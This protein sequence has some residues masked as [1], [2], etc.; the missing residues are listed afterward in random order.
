MMTRMINRSLALPLAALL[1]VLP[2][3][4]PQAD[5]A[6][7]SGQA[8]G[9]PAAGMAAKKKGKETPLWT[10]V[11]G[12]EFDDGVI[13]GSKWTFDLTNGASVGNPGWGNNE[14]QYYTNR[15]ENVKEE[16]GKLVITAL[17][18]NY[19][20]FG[21]TSARIKTK[22]L[23][24][25]RYGK[26]EI[27]A[28]APAGKGYWPAI[29]M[30][31]EHN[32]YGGWAASGEIDIMEGWGSR[33]HTIAGT[34]HYGQQWPSNTYSGKEYEL[35]N[36]STIEDYHTY[37]IEWEPGEI[38]W[39]VDGLL[40]ST[41]NDW[42]SRSADQP[43]N[44]AYPAPFD[45][46]FH[47]L[48]NLA[49]GG[50][51]DGSP[52]PDT[53]FPKSM[54]VDYVRVY[55]LT[56]RE[57]REP[58][59]PTVAKEEYLPGAKLPQANGS[60]IYN[61][62]FTQTLEADPGM[63]I[64]GTAHW[65]LYKDP[66]AEADVSLENIGGSR[67]A[68][69]TVGQAGSNAYSIQPQAIV[70]LAK[71]R[72]YKLSFDAKT[73]TA[74]SMNVKVTGGASVGYAGYSQGLNAELTDSVKRYEM[75]F[76][77]KMASDNAARIEFNLGS[78]AHP[79]WIGNARL[80]E[81]EGIPFEH[82]APKAPLSSGNHVYNGT[83]DIGEPDGMSYWHLLPD[84]KA[85]A[86]GSVDA[87]ERKLNV[88]ITKNGKKEDDVLLL[89]KGLFLL[90]GHD[91]ALS[92]DAKASHSRVIG[93]ELAGGDGKTYAKQNVTLGRDS[94]TVTVSFENLAAA[95]DDPNAQLIFHLGG[96]KGT[97][98][99]DNI[100]L[101]RTS[102]YF[103]PDTVFYPLAN[104]DFSGGLNPWQPAVDSGGAVT[105]K[106]V[107]GEAR[108][109]VTNQ[110]ANP[111]SAMFLQNG[112]RLQGGIP[113]T[114]S[115][116]AR[117]SVN[118]KLEVVAE[119]ASYTR[120]VDQTVDLT[121][122]RKTH[123]FDFTMPQDDTVDLKF[124]LG[125]I[126]GTGAVGAAHDVTIDNVVFQ[127]KDAPVAQPPSLLQDSTGNQAGQ[128]VQISFADRAAWRAALTF[129]SVNG[130][131][132]DPSAY[133]VNPG[134]LDISALAFPAA[135]S[136]RIEVQADGYAPAAVT[137]V[138]L[139]ADGN[140]VTNGGFT[141]GIRGWSTWSGEGGA[142]ELTAENGEA[143]I[144]VHSPGGPAW[145]N[146]LYQEGIP[147][148]A[149]STYELGFK[150]SSTVNRPVTVEFTGTSGGVKT[151]HLTPEAGVYTHR[152]TVD[153]GAPLKLNFLIGSV[154]ADGASTPAEAHGITLGEVRITEAESEPSSF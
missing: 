33:P 65:A 133:D 3:G 57:Y 47:L 147:M 130:I 17:K 2:L 45:E 4:A 79:A 6:A 132:L 72:Y 118:R 131:V 69:V 37:A 109:T 97:L 121:P 144:L 154:S 103:P 83:F 58:V 55:E 11:W 77:M 124:L 87:D 80:E 31:P 62:G 85:A 34:I 106:A 108:L 128:D 75:A 66:G 139:A 26:F 82:D 44:N 89:Q 8:G 95:A 93:V 114:F 140:L 92:F 10:Q 32:R 64:P 150:A 146:Q 151:F 61:S 116:D 119:N 123:R 39:Y 110:G 20:G 67:F 74:R 76:Q 100:R 43:A 104:G 112:L 51:F 41:K 35:P 113:Y 127:V 90:D 111:W 36:G 101:V 129:V 29:W 22:G 28:S 135:G 152:F 148:T 27:R 138:I 137:Q 63:G 1:A 153:S 52:A 86:A 81:I 149:G 71:G 13:D 14:L 18:E 94:R 42:Y 54:K 120:Y 56:G 117:A 98:Q 15:P 136:Y 25:K 91:Y 141:E 5:A 126:T 122:E 21:Y 84:G 48:M 40:Y 99:F 53:V 78:N 30:L 125:L 38:R 96:S 60:L 19:E 70:S 115:F 105:A 88:E 9:A 134:S 143:H 50:N 102:T 49:V 145:A 68:K 107:D 24:A 23:F 7:V 142:A 73:D 12:D 59:P 16:D 46:E